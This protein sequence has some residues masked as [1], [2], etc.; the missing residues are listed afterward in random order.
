MTLPDWA[1]PGVRRG[2]EQMLALRA[3]LLD[4]GTKAIGWKLGFGAPAWLDKFGLTGPVVGFLTEATRH[5]PGATVA[6]GG[7]RNPVAE[8]EIAVHIGRDVDN[9]SRVVDSIAA[10][11]PAIELADVHPPPENIQD[12]LAGN[13]FH[14]A[15][16][17]GEPDP[18]RAGGVS[19]GLR[20]LIRRDGEEVA[21]TTDLETFTGELVAILGHA[22]TM[23]GN[24]G[25]GLRAGEVVIMGSIVP[26]IAVIAGEEINFE[27]S[28]LPAISVRV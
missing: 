6:C 24:A 10:L 7:W 1:I 18:A 8:P 13:I 27:L 19:A 14:R 26:P 23:L 4:E 16:I 12:V 17:L 28:P 11:G 9:P 21:D 3:Q 5:P 20:A 15:V 22:A 25:E 2:I